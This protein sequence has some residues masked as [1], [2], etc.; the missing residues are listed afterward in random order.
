LTLDRVRHDVALLARSGLTTDEFVVEVSTSL[1]RAIPSAALCLSLMD[2]ATTLL[3]RTYK[4]GEMAAPSEGDLWWALYEYGT[5]N[6]EPSAIS[7]MIKHRVAAMAV[8]IRDNPDESARLRDFIR[9]RLGYMDELRILAMDSNGVWGGLSLFR[10]DSDA[11]F[12]EV[13]VDWV[14]G[15]AAP[16]A[17]GLRASLVVAHAVVA[18]GG[19]GSGPAV[20]VVGS[21]D[22]PR[23]VS[24]GAGELAAAF[25]EGAGDASARLVIPALLGQARRYAAGHTEL[26]AHT[27]VR[28][29]DGRWLMLHASPLSGPGGFEGDVAITIEEARP[30]DV[31][32]LILSGFGLSAREQQVVE[33]VIRGVDTNEIA[34]TLHM[35]AYTVQDHLKSI[36]TKVDVRSRRELIV[37]TFLGQ[38]APRLGSPVG[39]SGSFTDAEPREP[40]AD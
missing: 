26:L 18:L 9:P 39:P 37:R 11:P 16:L 6:P 7:E 24:P 21:D 27:R 1:S 10:R 19:A 14:A 32:P 36:F 29:S 22:S 20:I 33:L 8:S 28:R 2:P 17:A 12:S 3:T 5:E 40:V 25:V 23:L 31:L 4:F 15:L 35:S 34:G 13:E 30:P 38:Y